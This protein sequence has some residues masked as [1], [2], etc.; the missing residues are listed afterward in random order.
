M[1][2]LI[3]T[4]KSLFTACMFVL[5]AVT[6]LA[7]FSGEK[8]RPTV[9][10]ER[11][12]VPIYCVETEE[13]KV[14]I[15]FDAAWGD[16][17]TDKLIDILSQYNAKAT[18]FAVGQWA[19]KYPDSLK[20]F[21]DAGH[22]IAN[23]SY[24]H[25][26]Y[27]KLS[28]AEI[29]EDIKKGN[30]AIYNVTGKTPT[31]LRSPSGAYTDI[32][33]TACENQKMRTVQWSVDSLDWQGISVDDMIKRVVPA[34]ENGSIILFHN[35]VK[36]TPDALREILKQLSD[37]GFSFVTVSE[38]IYDDNYVIDSTGKQIKAN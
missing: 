29:E 1:K 14:A 19:E 4:K 13:K 6:V 2:L 31:L 23:H 25:T 33:E 17:D 27:N 9:A 28:Q 7:V 8:A 35:D 16:G 38:L 37:K 30:T 32:S 5:G 34:C 15:T 10:A 11:K 12:K 3:L 26:L 36:N 24:A 22:E 21:S 18:L 20:K